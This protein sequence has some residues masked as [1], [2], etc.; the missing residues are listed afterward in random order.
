[1]NEKTTSSPSFVRPHNSPVFALKP[2]PELALPRR[3]PQ[4]RTQ[5]GAPTFNGSANAAYPQSPQQREAPSQTTGSSA[6]SGWRE[7]GPEREAAVALQALEQALSER[8]RAVSERECRV[9]ER[10]RD[11][12]EAEVLLKHHEA[13]IWAAK[14][15]SPVGGKLSAEVMKAQAALKAELDRQEAIL[16]ESREALRQREKFIE[17]SEARLFEKVQEQQEKETELEQRE[18]E[19]RERANAGTGAQDGAKAP[20][21]KRT[22]D[23][24]NE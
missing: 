23:E 12:S 4:T 11:L 19:L 5:R 1:M 15:A 10:E 22:F 9:G 3:G 14:K 6:T 8:E 16:G 2:Q 13:L 7:A 17:E 24:F 18:E 20:Q 21:I